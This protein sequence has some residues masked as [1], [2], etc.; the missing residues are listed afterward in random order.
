MRL[1]RTL[2]AILL[3]LAAAPAQAAIQGEWERHELTA[4]MA[5]MTVPHH[6][7]L[8]IERVELPAAIGP[9][10]SVPCTIRGTVTAVHRGTL[11]VGRALT[12]EDRCLP[13]NRPG[14]AGIPPGPM[15]VGFLASKLEKPGSRLEAHLRD[16]GGRLAIAASAARLLGDGEARPAL[17]V[18]AEFPLRGGHL[19]GLFGFGGSLVGEMQGKIWREHYGRGGALNGR[20]GTEPYSG[21]WT[22]E[23]DRLCTTPAGSPRTCGRLVLRDAVYE[24]RPESGGPAMIVAPSPGDVFA[25]PSGDLPPTVT[26]RVLKRLDAGFVLAPPVGSAVFVSAPQSATVRVGDTVTVRG[27]Y[28]Q[29]VLAAERVE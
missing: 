8:R 19:F 1:A 7:E 16:E 12:L 3:L 2:A 10:L 27:A 22:I 13:D 9:R 23:G 26:G 28:A 6:V 24:Y 11:A 4:I 5:R 21:T 25:R 20:Y 29:G 17:P 15:V 14:W 18:P